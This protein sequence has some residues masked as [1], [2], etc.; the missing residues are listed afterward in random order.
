MK[1]SR[2]GAALLIVPLYIAGALF[3]TWLVAPSVLPGTAS[4]RAAV[5][6]ATT[7]D[8]L[9]AQNARA[10]TAAAKVVKIQE[11]NVSAPPSPAREFIAL[12]SAS[13][14]S[15]LPPPN[16]AAL[17]AAEQRRAAVF[18]GERDE[19]RR[20]Y[21]L[22]AENSEKLAAK[23]EQATAARQAADVALVEAAAASHRATV[24]AIVFLLAFSAAGATALW[25][26]FHF[27]G[28]PQAIGWGMSE[29]KAQQPAAFTLAEPF[30]TKYLDRHEQTRVAQHSGL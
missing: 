6:T 9:T 28:I 26:K 7:A 12:E 13:A 20:L 25:L 30:L 14:L 3:V 24:A 16:A 22:E 15:D 11:A 17:I 8:L 23:L 18:A 10:S 21:G 5:S 2:S 19:A 27:G 1:N 4:H 29:L